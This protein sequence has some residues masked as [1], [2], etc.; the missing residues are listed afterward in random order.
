M[1]IKNGTV[2]TENG[3][4]EDL[5]VLTDDE[6]ITMLLPRGAM[7]KYGGE[8]VDAEGCY[9]LPALVDIHFHG[10]AG[11]DFCEGTAEAFAAIAEYEFSRGVTAV[12]PATMTLPEERLAAILE[13]AAVFSKQ[14]TKQG[15]AK[16]V[17]IHMEGPFVNKE[18]RGAQNEAY[19]Q[20]ASPEKLRRWQKAANGMVK[21]VTLAPETEGAIECISECRGEFRFSLGHT[22][23]DYDTA[24]K[25]LSAGADHITHMF[26][27]MPPFAHRETGVIGA[28]FDDPHCFAEIIADGVHLSPTAVRAAFRL[29]GDDRI[30][31]ISDSMEATG[32]PDGR[33]QLGG[34]A[35]NVR[36]NRALLDNGTL[37]GSVTDLYGCLRTAVDMGI[38]LESA[39][40][41][42]ALNPA[43]SIGIDDDY[44]S[45]AVG[46]RAS[47]L[48]VDKNTLD[49]VRVI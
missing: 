1:L 27:A 48:L 2:F 28:A 4:F 34:Q 3:G 18:K 44:G 14:G 15:Q 24:R 19:I 45:I 6:R 36:G 47:F 40:K 20:Q 25:A 32:M 42:A 21:L 39:V 22:A 29:F 31:L 8:V 13:S 43:V 35:V 26:N 12:C 30:V 38:P 46:K 9:V 37:A 49:I 10:C 7:I 11:H 5:S 41:A 23:A 16:L 17:G 33:Y